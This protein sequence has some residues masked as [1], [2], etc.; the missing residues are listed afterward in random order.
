MAEKTPIIFVILF[1]SLFF[2]SVSVANVLCVAVN[3]S[4]YSRSIC[5]K[6]ERQI[7]PSAIQPVAQQGPI[8]LTGATGPQGPIGLTGAAGPQGPIGL[9]GAA[10]PQGPVGLTGAAGP[11]GPVGLTGA[12]GPQGPVGLTG[13]TGPQGPI[14]LTGAA[15]PQGPIG[16]VGITG[17]QGPSG[18]NI[19]KI[20]LKRW[21]A[22]NTVFGSY[23]IE[24]VPSSIVYDGYSIFVATTI[25]GLLNIKKIDK[26]TGSIISSISLNGSTPNSSMVF[27]G[28]YIWVTSYGINK[29][30]KINPATSQVIGDFSLEGCIVSDKKYSI[31]YDGFNI[32][33]SC[34]NAL[35]LFDPRTSKVIFSN[36][37]QNELGGLAFDG[38]KVW[39]IM[40]DGGTYSAVAYDT[41]NRRSVTS[42]VVGASP[43]GIIYDG[44]S[45]WVSNSGDG[46]VTKINAASGSISGV[47]LTGAGCSGIAFDG[48]MI[49]VSNTDN[50]TVTT[51]NSYTGE[52]IGEYPVGTNPDAI[53]FDGVNMWIGNR[54]D[55]TITKL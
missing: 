51:L 13:A 38:E 1:F 17:A 31:T 42:A 43:S 26:N 47:Y 4:V 39:Y 32:V 16:A 28:T 5:K 22:V 30:Y 10:G 8:G 27:D 53:V 55:S 2:S 11:Q 54:G 41:F 7:D 18:F 25:Q 9:T 52:L 24:G 21:Y 48:A 45:I 35:M 33:V 12:A 6:K 19:N 34:S 20:A 44:K 49:W 46:T 37:S 36:F 3:G 40:K 15:G 23:A 29:L 14:G 50:N